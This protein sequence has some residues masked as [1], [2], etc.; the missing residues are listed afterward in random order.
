MTNGSSIPPQTGPPDCPSANLGMIYFVLD[1]PASKTG[2]PMPSATELPKQFRSM[3]DQLPSGPNQPSTV[4]LNTLNAS[5]SAQF[6]KGQLQAMLSSSRV[7]PHPMTI[8]DL[9]QECHGFLELN[10]PIYGETS[11]AVG[12]YADRDWMNIGCDQVSVEVEENY[13]LYSAWETHQPQINEI[14]TVDKE[15]TV[16]TVD[17]HPIQIIG[18]STEEQH[19]YAASCGYA[20]LPAT[21]HVRP[22]D[23]V[24]DTFVAFDNANP[25]NMW[26][27]FH[28]RGGDG[29][30][31]TF[32]AM[33]DILHNYPNVALNDILARQ[34]LLGG[35]DLS[36][37][38][39]DN[40]SFKYPYAVERQQF[41]QN[42]ALYVS[43]MKDKGSFYMTWSQWVATLLRQPPTLPPSG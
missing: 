7:T 26:L 12:W 43:Q 41:I 29:R 14:K 4:G 5:G 42:F 8:V 25:T 20:R 3:T 28:C 11:I 27:H 15:G 16:C 35:I 2:G 10:Q 32:L 39:S 19:A 33:H 21:D 36:S 37:A 22:R 13:L 6:C 34:H 9:R 17:T 40:T 31:T 30:T 38:G 23:S 18:W 24:V 1:A